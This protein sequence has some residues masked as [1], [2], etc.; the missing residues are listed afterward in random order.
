MGNVANN[1]E[2]GIILYVSSYN[3]ILGN[4]A[5]NNEWGINLYFSSYSTISGN[6]LIGN[7]E[8][9]VEDNCRDNKFKDNDCTPAPSS[10][11][12]ATILFINICII[13]V[14][15]FMIYKNGKML[16]K[17]QEDLDFL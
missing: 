8:C 14:S 4:T 5:N 3:T 1:N 7:D 15:V 2:Y 16:K 6:I 12:L 11:Y 9:I 13:G 17:P 10:N